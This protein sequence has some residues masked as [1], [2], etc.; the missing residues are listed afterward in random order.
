MTTISNLKI[1]DK[2]HL[3]RGVY[4]AYTLTD[5]AEGKTGK[6]YY[7]VDNVYMKTG[8]YKVIKEE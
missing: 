4:K 2:F 3:Q 8:N 5:I 7:I 1:G 6:K